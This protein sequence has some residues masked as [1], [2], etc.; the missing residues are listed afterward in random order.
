MKPRKATSAWEYRETLPDNTARL[1]PE[2]RKVYYIL[3]QSGLS[4][5]CRCKRT[6][7]TQVSGRAKRKL[8]QAKE[9][10]LRAR[11]VPT[12]P[13]M[14]AGPSTIAGQLTE[15]S[16][17]HGGKIWDETRQS[18]A[19]NVLRVRDSTTSTIRPNAPGDE[20]FRSLVVGTEDL[21]DS[22]RVGVKLDPQDGLQILQNFAQSM[23][24][25]FWKDVGF[26]TSEARFRVRAA[27]HSFCLTL[28][29]SV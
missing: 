3:N 21:L 18:H 11:V 1:T 26:Q 23:D 13:H 6:A 19:P 27:T 8:Q 5:C 29:D 15:A 16:L 28:S 17:P 10:E 4:N 20:V 12:A 2:E 24:R 9:A 22:N 25:D 7:S 14:P